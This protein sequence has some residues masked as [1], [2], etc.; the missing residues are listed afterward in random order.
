MEAV[1]TTVAISPDH[2]YIA[3]GSD[4][5]M[6]GLIDLESPAEAAQIRQIRPT[7]VRQPKV[8]IKKIEFSPDG[9]W[10]AADDGDGGIQIFSRKN[11]DTGAAQPCHRHI[12]DV[13]DIAISDDGR[14]ILSVGSDAKLMIS[15]V[16]DQCRNTRSLRANAKS[17]QSIALLDANAKRV[18]TGSGDG[19]IVLWSLEK[20]GAIQTKNQD[21]FTIPTSIAF[22]PDQR[23]VVVTGLAEHEGF[24]RAFDAITLA[25]IG[26]RVAGLIGPA[27]GVIF[28]RPMN[29][30]HLIGSS[31]LMRWADIGVSTL[32]PA[33]AF[34]EHQVFW[35]GVLYSPDAR[36]VALLERS[37]LLRLLDIP[38]GKIQWEKSV[39]EHNIDPRSV[40]I[41]TD[42]RWIAVGSTNGLIQLIDTSSGEP[43]NKPFALHKLEVTGMVFSPDGKR[44]YSGSTDARLIVWD[45]ESGT[46][47]SLE[48]PDGSI[49]Q[50]ALSNDGS[51]LAASTQRGVINLWRTRDG[52]RLGNLAAGFDAPITAL[53]FDATGSHLAAA[54]MNGD[55]AT[56]PVDKRIWVT[57]ACE[58]AGR[59]LSETERTQ[60][61]IPVSANPCGS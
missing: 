51:V 34:L 12:N 8:F 37:G 56:W 41:S 60:F 45:L 36:T 44:L 42:G 29:T 24:A 50:I 57:R 46:S 5:G 9:K 55:F 59:P 61:L 47:T 54:A 28:D 33:Q 18:A 40:A 58:I 27:T 20:T 17:V 39:L 6:I 48:N 49:Q 30:T 2:R 13:Y 11:F 10:L 38:S 22:S 14:S 1:L 53:G 23:H 3:I 52:T 19:S 4:I 32:E 26:P 16:E 35:P 7:S 15:L 25:P 21:Q 43:K 31:G